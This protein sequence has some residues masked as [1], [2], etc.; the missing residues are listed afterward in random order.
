MVFLALLAASASDSREDLEDALLARAMGDHATARAGFLTLSR[1]LA[2][3]D[4]VRS[5]ALYWLATTRLERDDFAGARESLRECIRTG[6]ARQECVELLGRLEVQST[7]ITQIPTVWGFEGDHGVVHYWTQSDRGSIRIEDG[8]GDAAL[9]WVS[10]HDED[11]PGTL[12]FGVNAPT[13][14]PRRFVATM[15]SQG[16]DAR[17]G[18]LFVDEYGNAY[19]HPAA[20]RTLRAGEPYEMSVPLRE[21]RGPAGLLDPTHLER[22]LIRDLTAEKD[23]TG[24]STILVL[25]DVGLQ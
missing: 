19:Q 8:S 22:V 3:E 9:V 21:A 14:P 13:P 24:G 17:V 11:V 4:P 6:P 7:A 16:R 25:D 15:L 10:R 5:W 20:V 12:L 1:S 2:A 18:V 23:R